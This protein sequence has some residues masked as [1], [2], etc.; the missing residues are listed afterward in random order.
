MM[1][2]PLQLPAVDHNPSCEERARDADENRM[3]KKS[4]LDKT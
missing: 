4:L 2:T 1:L 3:R